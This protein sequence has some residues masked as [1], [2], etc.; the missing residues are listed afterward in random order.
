MSYQYNAV[1]YKK[2]NYS[3]AEEA[4]KHN[5]LYSWHQ[6]FGY[7]A[8][9]DAFMNAIDM[10]KCYDHTSVDEM[11]F[12]FT[13]DKVKFPEMAYREV[14]EL[15]HCSYDNFNDGKNKMLEKG[16]KLTVEIC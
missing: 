6:T 14:F 12:I 1:Y 16:T 11:A 5:A 8:T 15:L 7:S 4:K 2:S 3:S 10:M 9:M 13:I